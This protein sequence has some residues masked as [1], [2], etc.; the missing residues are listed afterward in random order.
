MTGAQLEKIGGGSI[1]NQINAQSRDT[2]GMG[3]VAISI[4]SPNGNVNDSA[5]NGDTLNSNNKNRLTNSEEQLKKG[6]N[7]VVADEK[8]ISEKQKEITALD[9][10]IEKY[11]LLLAQSENTNRFDSL[12]GYDKTKDLSKQSDMSYRKMVKQSSDLLP[13]GE[14]KRFVTGLSSFDAGMF[15]KMESKYTMS[16]QM[17]KGADVGYQLGIVETA[18]MVGK[19]QYVGRDGTL[20]KYTCY[21]G[22][23]SVK[24]LKGQ[25]LSLLYY[26]YT[27]DHNMITGDA[28]FKDASI[29]APSF[30]QPVHIVSGKYDASISK[31]VNMDAEVATSFQSSD[32]SNLPAYTQSDKMAYHFAAD[33]NIPTTGVTLLGSYENT[34]KGFVN[35]TLPAS[36]SGT[37]Q[38]KVGGKSSFFKSLLTLGIEY[39]Y[40]IQHNYASQSSNTKWGFEGKLNF[41]KIPSFSFSYKPFTT[42]QSYNDTLNIPQRLLLGS[43]TTAK[44]TYRIRMHEK[45]LNFSLVYNK[46]VTTM[47]S[48]KTGTQMMQFSTIYSDKIWNATANIGFTHLTGTNSL[49]IQTQPDNTKFLSLTGD[50]K[51]NPM[52]SISGGQDFGLTSFG[53]CKYGIN[54]GTSYRPKQSP[55]T[56]RVNIRYTTYQLNKGD[57]WKQLFSG[58][59]DLMYRFK[60]KTIKNSSF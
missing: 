21:S 32:K 10:K 54:A 51:L 47:D 34:G 24:P 22:R 38:Y 26:G 1:K 14:A 17:V 41:K 7:S 50:Y 59:L 45:S 6:K 27:V 19:T 46:S 13:D 37:A 33:G 55:L 2:S 35:N 4:K 48:G 42:F 3:S 40:L 11:Q 31:V 58:K 29:S 8:A 12:V 23:V 52:V 15:P 20:D 39:N 36:L 53:F 43:V 9:K 16:G 18:V 30:F 5:S 56:I 28:F 44:S 57:P 25:K 49:T 60:T